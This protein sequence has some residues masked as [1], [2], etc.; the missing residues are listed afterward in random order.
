MNK[1]MFSVFLLVLG[2][3]VLSGISAAAE[4]TSVSYATVYVNTGDTLWTIAG[5]HVSEKEDIREMIA[6]IKSINKLNANAEI[7]PGQ[8]IKIPVRKEKWSE[9][10]TAIKF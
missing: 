8:E 2:W 3:A 6:M 10:L 7:Q 4:I 9:F 5:K 1:F